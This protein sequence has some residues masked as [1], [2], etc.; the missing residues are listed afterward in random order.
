[1]HYRQQMD[2]V[3]VSVQPGWDLLELDQLV[4]VAVE[5]LE[6]LDIDLV[7]L[8]VVGHGLIDGDQV[9]EVDAQDGDF[10]TCTPAVCLSII[11]IV[12]A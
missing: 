1:M 9:F 7:V 8:H 2:Q 10:E 12:S 6:L 5:C 4:D 11:V 3:L